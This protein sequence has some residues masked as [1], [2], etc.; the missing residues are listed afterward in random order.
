MVAMAKQKS[1]MKWHKW[2]SVLILILMP[3]G[4]LFRIEVRQDAA[5]RPLDVLIG[6]TALYWVINLLIHKKIN[7]TYL[8]KPLLIFLIVGVLSLLIN[9]VNFSIS[10]IAIA[11]LYLLRFLSYAVGGMIFLKLDRAFKLKVIKGVFVGGLL[12]VLLGYVQY[13]LYPNLRNLYYL[14]WDEHNHRLFSTFLDPNYAGAFLVLFLLFSV[15]FMILYVRERK[16]REVFLSAGVLVVTVI[17][18]FLT[19]SRSAIL[20]MVFGLATY[21]WLIN[22]KRL[23]ILL[24]GIIIFAILALSPTFNKEN[25]NLFRV[26]SSL[27]R[28]ETYRNA[29]KIIQDHPIL[30][31]GFNTYRYAQQSYGFRSKTTKYSSHAD[32]GTDSSL[33]FVTATTGIVGLA[34]Y[35]YIWLVVIKR[36]YKL[37]VNNKKIFPNVAI[38]SIAGLAVNSLFINSLFFTSIMLWMWI[39][40]ALSE[41]Y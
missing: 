17:A 20:M 33:L 29:Q 26:T 9:M 8:N 30:G 18:I 1:K 19:Y 14:G 16:R 10:Q 25:T 36:M 21:L 15:G 5:I 31:V 6:I 35:L 34:A 28:V 11:S 2:L 22:R 7:F 38:S 39:L 3:F 27:A 13:F 23:I 4:E 40:I 32:A 41:D 37:K 12:V 24:L